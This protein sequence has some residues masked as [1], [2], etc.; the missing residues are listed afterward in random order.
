MRACEAWLRGWSV[1]RLAAWQRGRVAAWSVGRRERPLALGIRLGVPQSRLRT[2]KT[3]KLDCIQVRVRKL[4]C[5]QVRVR[6]LDCIRGDVR[7]V[8]I[9]LVGDVC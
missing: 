9:R 8:G 1:G 5:I 4:D 3:Y 7:P 6:K 2:G